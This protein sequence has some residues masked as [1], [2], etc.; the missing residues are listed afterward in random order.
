MMRRASRIA[1]L[2]VGGVLIAAA[3]CTERRPAAVVLPRLG[4]A[5]LRSDVTAAPD[6][7]YSKLT[8]GYWQIW[9]SDAAGNAARQLTSDPTDKRLPHWSAD[10]RAVL[11]RTAN[12]EAF[13][14]RLDEGRPRQ[15]LPGIGLVDEVV[16]TRDP[17]RVIYVR[18]RG[19]VRDNC[20]VWSAGLD[21]NDPR[22]LTNQVGLQWYP[23]VSPDG[24]Y[25]AFISSRGFGTDELCVCDINGEN[26]R[27]FTRNKATEASPAWSP[28]GGR[29]AYASDKTGDYE[30]WIV[31][32]DGQNCR[33]LTHTESVDI[34]PCWS[35]GGQRIAFTS[36]RGGKL[37]VWIMNADGTGPRQL[38]AGSPS[39]EPSWRRIEP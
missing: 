9:V 10:G 34:D 20:D 26:V 1:R 29:I 2:A 24:R 21:A 19:N 17:S 6:L 18:F 33:Q 14:I 12:H 22:M 15:I 4:Q 5:P 7:A 28:G 36:D 11:C 31:D 27:Q 30:I 32:A 25:L 23:R 13:M 3:G 37:Q 38:T 39:R 35:P 16:A 8:G